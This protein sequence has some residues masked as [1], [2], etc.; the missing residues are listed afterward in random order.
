MFIMLVATI[1]VISKCESGHSEA[2]EAR[3]NQLIHVLSFHRVPAAQQSKAI[4]YLKVRR[5]IHC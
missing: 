1:F 5:M 2:T 3:I 4:E